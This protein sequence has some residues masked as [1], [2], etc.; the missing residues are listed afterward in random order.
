MMKNGEL[1]IHIMNKSRRSNDMSAISNF[2]KKINQIIFD[3]KTIDTKNNENDLF[4]KLKNTSIAQRVIMTLIM[5]TRTS[6]SLN[7]KFMFT[8]DCSKKVINN[9][10]IKNKVKI[11]YIIKTILRT[12]NSISEKS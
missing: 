5:K 10:K 1:L 4:N 6:S 3:S 8:I 2:A 9:Q 12:S 11:R 7:E